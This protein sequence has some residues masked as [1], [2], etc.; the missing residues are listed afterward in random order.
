MTVGQELAGHR[1]IKIQVHKDQNRI[2]LDQL[3]DVTG[4]LIFCGFGHLM[5]RSCGHYHSP[6]N[7]RDA[8]SD[9]EAPR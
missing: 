8:I 1:Q 3:R 2:Y 7:P 9:R 6:K 5:V 4:I